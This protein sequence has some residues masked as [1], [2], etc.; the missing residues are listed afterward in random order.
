MFFFTPVAVYQIRR[1][2]RLRSLIILIRGYKRPVVSPAKI[3]PRVLPNATRCLRWPTTVVVGGEVFTRARSWFCRAVKGAVIVVFNKFQNIITARL[4]RVIDDRY[5]QQ[6]GVKGG[7]GGY[8]HFS[9][10][11]N[12][13]LISLQLWCSSQSVKLVAGF[14]WQPWRKRVENRYPSQDVGYLN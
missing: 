4:K 9:T 6:G 2:C 3:R 10:S 11:T 13:R 12:Q 7:R 8:G 14:V 5:G 1:R